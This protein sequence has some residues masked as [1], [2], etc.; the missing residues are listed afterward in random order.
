MNFNEVKKIVV[1]PQI[2]IY[3]NI[4]KD[5]EQL[6][7]LLKDDNDHSIFSPWREWYEQGYRRGVLFQKNTLVEDS[8]HDVVKS[9]KTYM[10]D[11]CNIVEFIKKDYFEQ[12]RKDLGI[13]PSFIE[14]W[15]KLEEPEDEFY[16]DY[17]RYDS[18]KIIDRP[19]DY[20]LME[21]HIDEFPIANEKKLRRHVATINFYLNND[22]DGGEICAYDSVSNKSY[23]YKPM[24]GD[25]VIMPST[26]PFYHAV[27]QYFNADRY[28]LRA[29]IDY[30]VDPGSEWTE[31]YKLGSSDM[32][33]SI[34]KD[35]DEFVKNDLQIISISSLEDVVDPGE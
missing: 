3:R 22:Y 32:F 30:Q 12:F 29:F 28:F 31:K 15:N 7:N 8:D 1:A 19:K 34:K 25:V 27:K 17:F 5:N 20:L 13:W 23:Q 21:Y 10:N 16:I 9:E 11:I 35:E 4:F 26:E 14:D 24:P 33:D 18:T 6:I 2:V